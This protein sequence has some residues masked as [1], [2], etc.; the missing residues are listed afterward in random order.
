MTAFTQDE[1]REVRHDA[2]RNQWRRLLF[3]AF[4]I[5]A[6]ML[7]AAAAARWYLFSRDYVSTGDAYVAVSIA[8]VTPLASGAVLQV[9]VD[10]TQPVKRGTVLLVIDPRDAQLQL[11]QAQ[12]AYGLALRKV[13]MYFA[14]VQARQ[15]DYDSARLDYARRAKLVGTGAVSTEDVT[16]AHDHV[17]VTKAAL[18]AALALTEGAT[19]MTN[20]EVQAAKVA[21]DAAKLNLARTIVRAPVDGIVAQRQVQVGQWVA[22]GTPVMAIVPIAQVYVDANFKESQLGDVHAGLPVTLTSDL[23]GAGVTFH[24]RVAGLGAGTGAAFAVIPAEN[25]TGNWISVVQRVPVRISLD[26]K[27]L[28][29]HPLLV[30]L[31]MTATIDVSGP[32]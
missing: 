5:F 1:L 4:A 7:A 2:S 32:K 29:R 27:E 24:G 18:D 16:A 13:D 22:A 19:R 31:S 9:P 25:A 30:G 23:Y 14:D 8:Q 12:A 21:L 3:A 26:P 20:P 28:S 10:N 11:A 15:A 17:A 6:A